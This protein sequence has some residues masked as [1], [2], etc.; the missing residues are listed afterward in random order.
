MRDFP[1]HTDLG[2]G[3]TWTATF[4]SHDYARMGLFYFSVRLYRH[5]QL[6]ETFGSSQDDR[7]Y[8]GGSYIFTDEEIQDYLFT[9]LN[10]EART[11]ILNKKA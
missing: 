9:V 2:E 4:D 10:N 3:W 7:G 6:V 8:G 5:G 1:E 11:Q